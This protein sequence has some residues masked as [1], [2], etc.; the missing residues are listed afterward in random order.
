MAVQAGLFDVD[1]RLQRLSELG[2]QLEAFAAAVD[3]ETF[4]PELDRALA[5]SDG[6]KGGRPPFD[7]VMFKL[8]VIQAANTLSDERLEYLT[9]DRLSFMRFLGLDLSDRGP[10]ARTIWL[11]REKP[12][13]AGA[14]EAL[15]DRFE[16]ALRAAGFLA[17][18]GQ[19]IDASLVAAPAQHA[20]RKG[21]PQSGS[22]A[23]GLAAQAGQA[24][25]QGPRRALDGQVHQGQAT[26]GRHG[27]GAR[28]G[29]PGLR[30]PQPHLNR[31]QVRPGPHVAGH[32]CRRARG[33]PAA[34]R[35]ARQ[36]QHR[37]KR[38]GG[39]G[40]QVPSA[41]PMEGQRRGIRRIG[42]RPTRPS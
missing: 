31:P 17:M 19:I 15:F 42:R 10:D 23:A 33:T 21:R 22:A 40:R 11:F 38:V 2:D 12:T 16:A 39:A 7:P 1:K 4:R 37:R 28:P 26:R 14:I 36:K 24:A 8:L 5:Y 35:P 18:S 30:P 13:K 6:S 3:F 27:A 32:G 25:P 34:R 20:S 41:S 9:N 29:D